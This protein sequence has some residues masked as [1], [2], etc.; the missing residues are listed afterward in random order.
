M[1]NHP[2]LHLVPRQPHEQTSARTSQ[3]TR[4]AWCDQITDPRD[5][6]PVPVC[7]GKHVIGEE[8]VCAGCLTPDAG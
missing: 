6:S 4:C 3:T 5:L 2:H 7:Q 1:K 8:L